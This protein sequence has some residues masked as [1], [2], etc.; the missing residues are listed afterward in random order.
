MSPETDQTVEIPSSWTRCEIHHFNGPAR[1]TVYSLLEA[2]FLSYVE[3]GI[4]NIFPSRELPYDPK[5]LL[6]TLQ[7]VKDWDPSIEIVF[8]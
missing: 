6:T 5:R 3:R 7:E 4:I 2:G 8:F 1:G